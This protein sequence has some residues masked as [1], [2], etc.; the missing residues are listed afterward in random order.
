MAS[1]KNG[2]P[3][4]ESSNGGGEKEE[5]QARFNV[6]A[7][8]IK[9]LSFESPNVP[10][11]L[12]G[13][14][15]NPNLQIGV[16]VNAE[17]LTDEE[18]EVVINFTGDAVNDAGTIYKIE[19]IYGGVFHLENI[20]EEMKRPLLLVD[21]PALLFPFV[22]RIVADTTRDGGFPPLLLDP[23][24]FAGLY[25]ANLKKEASESRAVN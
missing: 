11:V 19:L 1:D 14:G 21:C 13:P 9:D 8:F 3:K 16:N 20:P 6:L 12:R 7:Q 24:D 22:R 17:K 18:F 2:N 10:D 4:A 25:R 5:Q 23:I 15:E